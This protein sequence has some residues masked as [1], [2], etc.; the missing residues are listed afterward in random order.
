[1]FLT[2]QF[3]LAE[4]AIEVTNLP[5]NQKNTTMAVARAELT[6][7]RNSLLAAHPELR[8]LVSRLRGIDV[9]FLNLNQ[10]RDQMVEA[11]REHYPHPEVILKASA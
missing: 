9:Y 8:A 6:S 1:M 5:E 3:R 2:S 11:F 4:R 7:Q 10:L